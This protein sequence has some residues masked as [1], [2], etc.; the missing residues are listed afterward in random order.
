MTKRLNEKVMVITGAAQGIGRGCAQMAAREG[1]YVVIGDI[2]KEAGE[3]TAAAIRAAGGQAV[4]QAT[5]V[6]N[7]T[8]CAALMQAASETYGRIDVL[9]NNVG[10]FPRATLE[11]TTTELW[12]Q[13]LQINLRSAFY[14]C[15]YAIPAMRASGGGSIINIGSL[16]GIQGVPNLLA[17]SAAKGGLLSLT[18]T[19][20]GAHAADNIRVNYL[21]PGWVLSEGELALQHSRG[22]S[23]ADL[24]RAGQ[25]LR[26]GRHQTPE[27]VAYAVVYL[28]SDESAQVTGTILNIDAG[29]TTLPISPP[30]RLYV[31]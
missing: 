30:G 4:F 23:D 13:V 29:A 10:W 26:L 20:A 8:E 25:S 31:G 1:A 27:D 16:N 15:K 21:I 28:A 3:A 22:V 24:Q 5:N 17:Y 6:A 9:V 7:E 11:E 19:L 18:R 2:Q 12:E 14:C